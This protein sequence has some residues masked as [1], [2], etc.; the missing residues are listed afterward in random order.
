MNSLKWISACLAGRISERKYLT[1]FS[2]RIRLLKR[3]ETSTSLLWYAAY[4]AGMVQN[5]GMKIL[6]GLP[7]QCGKV[8]PAIPFLSKSG[9]TKKTLFFN[10]IGNQV[11]PPIR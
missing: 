10:L 7:W 6:A 2:V 3:V 9:V 4:H 11:N 5:I 1:S 8:G